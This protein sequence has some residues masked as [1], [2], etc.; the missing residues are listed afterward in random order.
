[1]EIRMIFS[2]HQPNFFPY[3]GLFYKIYQSDCFVFLDDVQFTKS[4]GPAHERNIISNWETTTYIKVP[5]QYHFGDSVNE[6]KINN[7]IDWKKQ[8]LDKLEICYKKAPFYEI[9]TN[10]I[11]EILKRDYNNLAELNIAIILYICRK[12]G[13]QCKYSI[14]SDMHIKAKRTERLAE[15]GEYLGADT[16]YSGTGAK[17]YM[18][19][20]LLRQKGISLIY[21]DYSPARYYK[22]ETLCL[23]NMSVLDY[24]F[25]Y[26]YDFTP[27]GW[28]KR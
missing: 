4:S 26:G 8:L 6:V 10:D 11:K 19:M 7:A 28:C 15:I 9:I 25:F 13:V 2:A 16:Y 17:A 12:C 23:D 3:L 20:Q 21:S 1:M 22:G 5:I 14:S 27:L 18:D 24:L